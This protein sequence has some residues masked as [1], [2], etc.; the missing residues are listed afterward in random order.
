M[1]VALMAHNCELR[2]NYRV[3]FATE[4]L[5]TK[6]VAERTATHAFSEIGNEPIADEFVK[7][8]EMLHPTCEHGLSESLCAGP[9]HYPMER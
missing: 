9:N 4:D 2:T 7:L 8:I 3:T 5:A 1:S 6:Y